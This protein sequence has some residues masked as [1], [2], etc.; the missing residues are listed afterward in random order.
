MMKASKKNQVL[1]SLIFSKI[2]VGSSISNIDPT[3]FSALFGHRKFLF[4]LLNP[5]LVQHSLKTALLF[6]ESFVKNNYHL[7]LVINT[8]NLTFFQKFNKICKN[9]NYSL[10]RASEISSGFLTNKSF[11]NIVIVTL[12]LDQRKSE[13]IQKESLLMKVPIISFSDLSSNKFS[14]SVY[15]F[16]NFNSFFSQNLILSLISICLEKNDDHS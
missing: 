7:F 12:F 1:N 16:G 5:F 2:C 6:L 3:H 14:S 10:L 9:K 11:S 15:V 8:Q 4:S 13:L